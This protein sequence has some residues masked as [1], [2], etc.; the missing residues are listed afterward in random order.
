MGAMSLHIR[1]TMIELTICSKRSRNVL[2]KQRHL[3]LSP[4][5]P[6]KLHRRENCEIMVQQDAGS[7]CRLR[8]K[9]GF[10]MLGLHANM[11][12]SAQAVPPFI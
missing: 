2:E 9:P 12:L 1:L 8:T 5:Y 7:G 6:K 3:S 4:H 10:R 11:G